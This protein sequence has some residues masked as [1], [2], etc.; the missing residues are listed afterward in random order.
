MPH[1]ELPVCIGFFSGSKLP[2]Y[3]VTHQIFRNSKLGISM[4]TEKT[5]MFILMAKK[6]ISYTK[7]FLWSIVRLSLEIVTV[8]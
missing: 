8:I 6:I 4:T 3:R 1:R 7:F 2:L 5:W